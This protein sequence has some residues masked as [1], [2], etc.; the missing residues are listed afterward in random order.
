MAN[1]QRIKD[2][3]NGLSDVKLASLASL[4]PTQLTAGMLEVEAKRG[5]LRKLMKSV[6]DLQEYLL[7][8]AVQ[9]R[10]GAARRHLCC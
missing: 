1:E 10:A 9:R 2:V 8:R 4:K 5:F 7:H 6:I 3:F